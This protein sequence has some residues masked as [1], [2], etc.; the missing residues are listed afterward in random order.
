MTDL[1]LPDPIFHTRCS[2]HRHHRSHGGQQVSNAR[3]MRQESL[4]YSASCS[5]KYRDKLLATAVR[6]RCH[7]QAHTHT[8]TCMKIVGRYLFASA[9]TALQTQHFDTSETR[10]MHVH[11]RDQRNGI[12][13]ISTWVSMLRTKGE[14][15]QVPAYNASGRCPVQ[16]VAQK[17]T[18]ASRDSK[19]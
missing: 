10:T 14:D 1:T 4:A 5:C 3:P 8:H 15:W 17:V 13:R 9:R 2:T 12:K 19:L 18:V 16:P 7:M 6:S 11:Q